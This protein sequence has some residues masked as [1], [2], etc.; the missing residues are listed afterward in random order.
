[1]LVRIWTVASIWVKYWETWVFQLLSELSTFHK[2]PNDICCLHV[3][4]SRKLSQCPLQQ[5]AVAKY[6]TTGSCLHVPRRS[7]RPV[8]YNR[9]DVLGLL[10]L[11]VHYETRSLLWNSEFTMELLVCTILSVNGLKAS[12]SWIVGPRAENS[13]IWFLSK[14]LVF[15]PKMSKWAIRSKKIRSFLVNNL[16]N[17]L[18]FAHF[19]WATWANRS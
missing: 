17:S 2:L 19:L 8:L 4:S 3:L 18:T 7:C 5:E 16:S 10:K 14:S 1:M 12:M 11:G 6:L 9:A 15:S 13:L